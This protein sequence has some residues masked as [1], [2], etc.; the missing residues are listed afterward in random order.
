[1]TDVYDGDT[2]TIDGEEWS[3]FPN[4][5]WKVRIRGIDTPEKRSKCVSERKLAERAKRL[6]VYLLS[7]SEKSR[8][9]SALA[10]LN[11]DPNRTA[12]R[13]RKP[14]YT[15]WLTA[16]EHDKYGGRFDAVVTLADGSSL[17][18]KLISSGLARP[19]FGGKKVPWC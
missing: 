7:E 13:K 3:P 12:L 10:E 11:D 5:T 15:V 16:V 17:G 19:Y 6:A 4:L 8:L 14:G 9:H 1:M 2:F 18:D